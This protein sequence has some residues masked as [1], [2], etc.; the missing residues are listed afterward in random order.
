MDHS[1]NNMSFE[2]RLIHGILTGM[3]KMAFGMPLPPCRGP[4]KKKSPITF[5]RQ[6][7]IRTKSV[8]EKTNDEIVTSV[9]SVADACEKAQQSGNVTVIHFIAQA[10]NPGTRNNV[11]T[12]LLTWT[13]TH[14]LIN[15]YDDCAEYM[16]KSWRTATDDAAVECLTKHAIVIDPASEKKCLTQGEFWELAGR[17]FKDEHE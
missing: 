7:T 13:R 1:A 2:A 17:V 15:S 16:H 4:H 9:W 8:V 6:V 10:V 11:I 3:K 12:I 5:D 14:W